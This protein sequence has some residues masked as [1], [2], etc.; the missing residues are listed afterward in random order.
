MYVVVV[1]L[2]QVGLAVVRALEQQGHEVVAID[3]DRAALDSAEEHHDVATL[4]GYGASARVLRQAGCARAD[5]IVAVTRQD[6]TNLVAALT[7]R[8]LGT[9][10]CVARVQGADWIDIGGEDGL[11]MGL[12]GVDAVFNPRVLA[13][14]ELARIAR[15]SGALEVLE[16]A[17]GRVEVVQVELAAGARVAGRPLM[18]LRLPQGM[19]VAAFVRSGQLS[20]PGGADVLRP[21]DRV[22]LVGLPAVLREALGWFADTRHAGRVAIIGGG[23]VGSSLA[24]SLE[25]TGVAVTLFERDREV[26]EALAP[27]LPE[28]TVVIGDGTD[29]ELLEEHGVARAD[30]LFGV[31]QDEQVNLMGALVGRR[32]GARRTGIIV[33]RSEYESIYQQLGIDIVVSP[34]QMATDVILRHC[35]GVEVRNLHA[36]AGGQADLVELTAPQGARGVGRPLMELDIPRGVLICGIIRRD[37]VVVPSGRDRIEA[38]DGVILLSTAAARR[39]AGR[40]FGTRRL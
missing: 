35:R 1:G 14:G 32:V 7:A 37:G 26:A 8:H 33:S 28:A 9:K 12:L 11:A 34:R 6:E 29:L 25:G 39:A 13:A 27:T 24:R 5:L 23:V 17:E 22:F 16:L 15:S 3:R 18:D 36:L 20:V 31:T 19:R 38:G 30:L 10:R 21:G 4:E 40:L 2:G